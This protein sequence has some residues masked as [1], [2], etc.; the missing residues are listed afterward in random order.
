MLAFFFFQEYVRLPLAE[1]KGFQSVSE[2]HLLLQHA[3]YTR[4]QKDGWE[5]KIKRR[6][7]KKVT[8]SESELTTNSRNGSVDTRLFL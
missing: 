7:E 3:M 2:L 6:R 8:A 1:A 4:S 5:D